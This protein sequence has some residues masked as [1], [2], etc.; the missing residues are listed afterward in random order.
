MNFALIGAP[1]SGKTHIAKTISA[2]LNLK[3]IECDDIFWKGQNLRVEVEKLISCERWI[4]DGHMSKISDLVF[5]KIQ[6][7]IIIESLSFRSLLRSLK[8]DWKNPSKA[9][10]N[11]QNYER[12]SNKREELILEFRRERPNDI[13]VLNNFPDLRESELAA[14]CENLKTTPVKATKPAIKRKRS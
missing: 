11:I 8:R 12:M 13:I 3:H 10:F 1:G 9:W 14:F 5:P 6:K 4:I 2:H 7:L